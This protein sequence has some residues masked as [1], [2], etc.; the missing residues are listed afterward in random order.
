MATTPESASKGPWLRVLAV[1]EIVGIIAFTVVVA[2]LAALRP[3]YSHVAQTVSALGEVGKPFANVQAINFVV[4][5]AVTTAFAF[6]LHWGLPPGSILGPALVA[7]FGLGII[8]AG[9]FPCLPCGEFS[10]F[11]LENATHGIAAG[12]A[13]VAIM[14]A[15]FLLSR[16]MRLDGRWADYARPFLV[17]GALIVILNV[18]F[19]AVTETA[20]MGAVQR[21][22]VGTIFV[23]LGLL[24]IRLYRVSR[25]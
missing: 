5:G 17:L 9:L 7:V 23:S 22:L 4:L 14:P 1:L 3:D 25:T 19:Y 24:A 11:T 18:M 12:I 20:V 6:G 2:V 21:A 16:R 8:G 13:F 10:T 15:P